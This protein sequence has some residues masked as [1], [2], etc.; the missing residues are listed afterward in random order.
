MTPTDG[1]EH[2]GALRPA[3]LR[4]PRTAPQQ[5]NHH[6]SSMTLLSMG[7]PRTQPLVAW[8]EHRPL[9]EG[10]Y[11]SFAQGSID[12]PNLICISFTLPGM[13]R[14]RLTEAAAK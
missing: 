7:Y 12:A 2:L 13:S 6:P 11:D 10:S 3:G 1:I 4:A 8:W 9:K 14:C 5:Y